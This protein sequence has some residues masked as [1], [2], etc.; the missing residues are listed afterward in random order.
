MC[1]AF[2]LS[3]GGGYGC[4]SAAATAV[5]RRRLRLSRVACETE[6]SEGRV[7]GWLNLFGGQLNI[8]SFP[9]NFYSLSVFLE[10]IL[11]L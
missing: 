3:L 1:K 7:F 4:L 6:E 5:S 11:S 10:H 9:V 2:W 8:D